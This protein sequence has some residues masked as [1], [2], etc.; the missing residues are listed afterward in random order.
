MLCQRLE[1]RSTSKCLHLMSLV[2]LVIDRLGRVIHLLL[3]LRCPTLHTRWLRRPQVM[4]PLHFFP[5]LLRPP[6][7]LCRQGTRPPTT[8]LELLVQVFLDL[9][10]HR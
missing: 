7:R 5:Q 9:L 4:V 6:T 2:P 10:L 1:S 8:P 3:C